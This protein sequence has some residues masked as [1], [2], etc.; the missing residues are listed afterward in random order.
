M[1]VGGGKGLVYVS[2]GQNG[3]TGCRPQ[4]GNWNSEQPLVTTK[5]CRI[6]SLSA[7]DIEE[8]L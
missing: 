1:V 6:A 5:V 2:K 4:E 7:Q 8:V 3:Q